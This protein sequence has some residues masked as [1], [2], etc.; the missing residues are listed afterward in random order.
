LNRLL[1]EFCKSP[2]NSKQIALG[3]GGCL[4]G[5]CLPLLLCPV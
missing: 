4:A 1:Y 2:H 5:A 3:I